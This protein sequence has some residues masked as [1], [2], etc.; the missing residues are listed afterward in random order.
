MREAAQVL[1]RDTPRRLD[2]TLLRDT[3]TEQNLDALMGG[4]EDNNATEELEAIQAQTDR[5]FSLIRT[6][7]EIPEGTRITLDYLPDSG[8]RL[9]IAGRVLGLIPGERF[10]RAVM[11]IWLGD[12]PIQVS[13]KKALLGKTS[14]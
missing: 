1:N 6:V 4:M 14:S 5:F 10:N 12:N 2:V 7:H 11:K 13:L 9:S 8:T 3:S